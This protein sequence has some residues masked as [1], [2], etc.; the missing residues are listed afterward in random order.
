MTF[1]R[2]VAESLAENGAAYVFVMVVTPGDQEGVYSRNWYQRHLNPNVGGR[3]VRQVVAGLRVLAVI[4]GMS[5][6][7]RE[8]VRGCVADERAVRGRQAVWSDDG[9]GRA[10]A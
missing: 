5:A 7:L 6:D 8:S 2:S 4:T 1:S 9:C 10:A 3:R